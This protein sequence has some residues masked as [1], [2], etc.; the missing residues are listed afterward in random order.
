M[1]RLIKCHFGFI[2]CLAILFVFFSCVNKSQKVTLLIDTENSIIVDSL[3]VYDSIVVEKR[4]DTITFAKYSNN[5]RPFVNKLCKYN[6][7]FYEIRELPELMRL[8][9]M[10]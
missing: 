2:C 6:G 5:G 9:K 1:N 7:D 4:L 8:C 10:F 3:F